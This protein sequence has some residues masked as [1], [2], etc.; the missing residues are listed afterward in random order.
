MPRR[1]IA[2]F[3]VKVVIIYGLFVLPWLRGP[4]VYAWAFRKAGTVFFRHFGGAGRVF[5]G[6]TEP[7]KAPYD[8]TV[9]ITNLRILR[10]GHFDVDT[11]N[12]GYLATA[13][14]FALIVASPVP[15]RRRLLAAILGVA[16]MSAFVWLQM[17]LR[18]VNAFEDP[19]MGPMFGLS[20]FW[21]RAL[22]MG[23]TVLSR[24][25]VTAYVG[26]LFVW[27]ALTIRREDFVRLGL[28]PPQTEAALKPKDR[29]RHSHA[30]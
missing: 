25:P 28:L 16:I 1:A 30:R 18:L 21:K 14:A 26:P 9:T 24:N 17:Y 6:P 13:F 5:F 22:D 8:T 2:L 29:T 15:W 10:T 19:A 27:A 4:D 3:F 23:I 20:P 7:R 11:R 12:M